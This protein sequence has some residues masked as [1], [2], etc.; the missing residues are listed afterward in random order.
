MRALGLLALLALPALAVQ[1]P[2]LRW[3][4]PTTNTDGSPLTNLAG[5]V[6]YHG[7]TASA[8]PD[9]RTLS[10]NSA[11]T[12][13]RW[14]NLPDG[15][16]FFV[17]T[18]VNT[19]N[20][21]GAFSNVAAVGGVVPPLGAPPGPISDLRIEEEEI[22][23]V[24]VTLSAL[25]VSN[26]EFDVAIAGEG[27][28]LISLAGSLVFDACGIGGSPP[29]PTVPNIGV[30]NDGISSNSVEFTAPLART[31]CDGDPAG[32]FGASATVDGVTKPLV[33]S[34]GIWTASFP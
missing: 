6:I 14:E 22:N 19:A 23:P 17:I 10:N 27:P 30:N 1:S 9:S 2:L 8:F 28:V 25:T 18:T 29:A 11:P 5:Y 15:P 16:H 34:G 12:T 24:L 21:E 7:T 26:N 20:Q 32:T 31:R 3:T 33:G 13:Y 4:P